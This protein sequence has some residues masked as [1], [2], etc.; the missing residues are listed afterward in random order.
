MADSICAGQAF[1]DSFRS[2]MAAIFPDHKLEPIPA[3]DPLLG[4]TYGGFDLRTVSRRD[5]EAAP[6]AGGPLEATT[7]K[8]P[9]ELEGINFRDHWGM[10]FSPIDIS[11]ALEKHDSLEC[12]GYTREDAARIGINVLRY[13]CP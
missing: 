11:C 9:P 2:E 1:T 4:T 5:P 6:T 7:R 3:S 13:A 8:V 12:R 10:I